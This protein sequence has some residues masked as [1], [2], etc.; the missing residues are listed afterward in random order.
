MIS[1]M[2][3]KL[4]IIMEF[5]YFLAENVRAKLHEFY[6]ICPQYSYNSCCVLALFIMG[7]PDNIVTLTSPTSTE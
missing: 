2:A 3:L 4:L 5:L 7:F 6:F 1:A